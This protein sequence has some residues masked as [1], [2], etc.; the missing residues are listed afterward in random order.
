MTPESAEKLPQ[1]R[2]SWNY[3]IFNCVYVGE[4]VHLIAVVL[5][6]D[7][8]G[9]ETVVKMVVSCPVWVLGLDP[10][11]SGRAANA[12]TYWASSLV[13]SEFSDCRLQHMIGVV[14]TLYEKGHGAAQYSP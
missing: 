6:G 10:L 11:S 3:F 8:G 2:V 9:P 14:K 1:S 4:S 13:L 5:R 12:L 7:T